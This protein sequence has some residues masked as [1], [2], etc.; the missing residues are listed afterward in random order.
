MKISQTI[1]S[2]VNHCKNTIYN[3]IYKI[4][5]LANLLIPFL[6]E[7]SYKI[8]EWLGVENNTWNS[9][10]IQNGI[11]IGD[12]EILFERLD[13]KVIEDEKKKLFK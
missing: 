7:S 4:V 5:N 10:E 6:P 13:K 12:F 2:D 11:L 1:H 9:I 8:M 3:L